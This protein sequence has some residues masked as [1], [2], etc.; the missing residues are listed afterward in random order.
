MLRRE[1]VGHLYPHGR[2]PGGHLVV[3]TALELDQ[4]PIQLGVLLCQSPLHPLV[5]PAEIQVGQ[6]TDLGS[7]HGRGLV[8]S[9]DQVMR[10]LVSQ[11]F[12]KLLE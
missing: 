6:L 8:D 5:E 10:R 12:R 1:P 9:P 11:R 7:V 3:E 2:E 4:A